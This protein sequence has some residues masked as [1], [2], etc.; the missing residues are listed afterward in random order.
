M[1]EHME[2]AEPP[3]L[4][5]PAFVLVTAS[6]FAY[7]VGIGMQA[8]VLPLFVRGPLG[9]SDTVV[10]VVVGA[11]GITAVL[12]RPWAGRLAD[13]HGRR[14]LM[15]VGATV[16]GLSVA[17]YAVAEAW[18]LLLVFRL[19]TGAGEALFFVGGMTVITDLAPEDRRGEALSIFSLGLFGGIAV[20]PVIGEFVLMRADF[21]MVWLVG[22]ATGLLAGLAVVTLHDTRPEGAAT[23]PRG[24]VIHPA[25]LMPA[26]I[27]FTNVCGQAGFHA[28]VALYALELGLPGAGLVFVTFSVVMLSVRSIGAKLPDRLG[29]KRSAL[30]ALIVSPL[31]LVVMAAAP[32]PAG[33]FVG[34]AVFAGGQS[35]AFPAI[36]SLAV[37]QVRAV[38]RGAV[39]G[40]VTA[41]VDVAFAAGAAALGVIA[42]VLGY[43]GAFV[44]AAVAG[45]IGFV[46]LLRYHPET[47]RE[48]SAAT[49]T[50][51]EP[52][53]W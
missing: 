23:Q 4:V 36:M 37:G 10:G 39:V 2:V 27:L 12:V 51:P 28:F 22:A 25:G 21:T 31:G 52:T 49:V 13:L 50:G 7:F 33:L 9:G 48:V 30:T 20:G 43:R 38:E 19:L 26:L 32:T 11:W 5:T 14:L 47:R 41:S 17:L 45:L 53:V 40:T 44:A 34:T 35:L 3:R 8:P 6:T 16:A 15:L 18:W 1:A 24:R 29:H 42:G 46:L